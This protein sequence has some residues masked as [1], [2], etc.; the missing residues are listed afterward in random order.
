MEI[1]LHR[2]LQQLM[3]GHKMGTVAVVILL[4]AAECDSVRGRNFM[5]Y[6]KTRLALKMPTLLVTTS[7]SI[8]PA[9]ATSTPCFVEC[10]L[11]AWC[12]Y[13]PITIRPSWQRQNSCTRRRYA[14]RNTVAC[15]RRNNNL[16][17]L[18]ECMGAVGGVLSNPAPRPLRFMDGPLCELPDPCHTGIGP[19]LLRKG[20]SGL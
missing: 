2:W 12:R 7:P 9:H 6:A 11:G 17:W 8:P 13:Q 1:S 16:P 4:G 14:V 19:V 18:R 10:L 20:S 5:A 3:I 15:G